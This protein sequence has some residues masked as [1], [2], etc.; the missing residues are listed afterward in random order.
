ME[1][2]NVCPILKK[3]NPCKP[4][5]YRPISL[6]NY[7]GKIMERC[8]HKDISEYLEE[9]TI[10]SEYQSGFKPTD[11][12]INQLAYHCNELAE[13]ID[14]SREIRVV[15]LDISKAFDIV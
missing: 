12:T 13:A 11:S 5:N 15:F 7:E 10:I 8:V 14:E 3:D 2:A 1:K 6:L 9:N 4:N